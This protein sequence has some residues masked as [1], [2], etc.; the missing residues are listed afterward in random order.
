MPLKEVLRLLNQNDTVIL[1]D[2]QVRLEVSVRYLQS[3]VYENLL[4]EDVFQKDGLLITNRSIP[5]MIA[6]I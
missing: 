3:P 6:S 1:I 4:E 5:Y 2:R